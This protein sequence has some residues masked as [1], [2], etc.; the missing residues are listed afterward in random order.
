MVR[1]FRVTE[2]IYQKSEKQKQCPN[3][4]SYA[5][6]KFQ[7]APQTTRPHVH[8]AAGGVTGLYTLCPE[9]SDCAPLASSVLLVTHFHE[10]LK[11][12]KLFSNS[13]STSPIFCKFYRQRVGEIQAKKCKKV[14]FLAHFQT[15]VWGVWCGCFAKVL[16]QTLI[17]DGNWVDLENQKNSI[18]KIGPEQHAS[19]L[20]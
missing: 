6:Y 2:N 7:T 18:W 13:S 20:V 8:S 9:W 10:M 5:E 16:Q 19:F 11:R 4:T 3:P 15:P 1:R 17:S 14:T 12:T